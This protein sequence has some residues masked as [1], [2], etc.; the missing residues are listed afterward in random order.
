M[1]GRDILCMEW[2]IYANRCMFVKLKLKIHLSK[3]SSLKAIK[4][5]S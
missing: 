2:T 4:N 5:I 1:E 3:I